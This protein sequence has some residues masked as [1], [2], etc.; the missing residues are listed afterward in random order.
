MLYGKTKQNISRS[1]AIGVLWISESFGC[2][3]FGTTPG[4]VWG[5][6]SLSIFPGSLPACRP[7]ARSCRVPPNPAQ[8][9]GCTGQLIEAVLRN[10]LASGTSGED[11]KEVCPQRWL[12]WAMDAIS[13]H[14]V[15]HLFG[16]GSYFH[17]ALASC[18]PGR[19]NERVAPHWVGF[20]RIPPGIRVERSDVDSPGSL[21]GKWAGVG[22]ARVASVPSTCQPQV[23]FS[24]GCSGI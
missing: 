21:S 13:Q 10:H 7:I 24:D 5:T 9:T 17:P 15:Y 18:W 2:N 1:T 3:A 14:S 16:K 11:S 22:A 12:R 20:L 23:W 19:P 8:C 4:N 6:C